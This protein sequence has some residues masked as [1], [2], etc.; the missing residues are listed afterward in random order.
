MVQ[1]MQRRQPCVGCPEFEWYKDA[2]DKRDQEL[3]TESFLFEVEDSDLTESSVDRKW[4][5]PKFKQTLMR[6][7]RWIAD[8]YKLQADAAPAAAKRAKKGQKNT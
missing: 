3:P 5:K 2:K 8:K 6:K 4:T 7:N 1:E